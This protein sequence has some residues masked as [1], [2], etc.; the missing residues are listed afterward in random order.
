MGSR[1][2]LASL[3]PRPSLA[4]VFD[5][6]QSK[7]GAGEGLGTRLH[8]GPSRRKAGWRA[9]DQHGIW[10]DSLNKVVSQEWSATEDRYSIAD[11]C[12]Y[13][14]YCKHT[15][16]GG[17]FSLGANFRNFCGQTCF[18]EKPRKNEQ[19]WKLMTSLCA[20]VD[21]NL[22]PCE[23]D[24]SLQSVCL[25]NGRCREESASYCTCTNA[26]K[27]VRDAPELLKSR[28]AVLNPSIQQAS[29]SPMVAVLMLC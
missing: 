26:N 5:P 16:Y 24:G 25:L 20:Y 14:F 27:P 22:Y 8:V 10:T 6:L 3:V 12:L 21:T 1:E 19:R 7:T 13:C 18:C 17:K 2:V 29:F 28:S 23:R 9:S 11:I 4:P 15:P